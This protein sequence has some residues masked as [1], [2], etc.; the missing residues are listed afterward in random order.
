[1]KFFRKKEQQ[2]KKAQTRSMKRLQNFLEKAASTGLADL[3]MEMK[4]LKAEYEALLKE[5]EAILPE[6]DKEIEERKALG[7]DTSQMEQTKVELSQAIDEMKKA[8][9]TVPVCEQA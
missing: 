4:G 5:T 7:D 1:M 8:L 2:K 9:A 6:L 3:A